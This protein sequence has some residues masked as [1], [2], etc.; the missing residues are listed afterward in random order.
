MM[1]AMTSKLSL[2]VGSGNSTETQDIDGCV[3]FA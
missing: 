1:L 3:Q 2:P